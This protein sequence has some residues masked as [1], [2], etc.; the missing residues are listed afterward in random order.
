MVNYTPWVETMMHLPRGNQPLASRDPKETLV[1][2]V[3]VVVEQS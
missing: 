2:R 3:R 1:L